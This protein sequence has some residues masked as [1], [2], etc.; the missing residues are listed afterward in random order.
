MRIN[1]TCKWEWESRSIDL[2]SRT[3]VTDDDR[4]P[5][6]VHRPNV[7]DQCSGSHESI[8]KATGCLKALHPL[9]ENDSRSQLGPCVCKLGRSTTICMTPGTRH[10]AHCSWFGMHITALAARS[11]GDKGVCILVAESL[12]SGLY[13]RYIWCGVVW[14]DA[15]WNRLLLKVCVRSTS[16]K[17]LS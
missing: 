6:L 17:W 14:C 4:C 1:L 11:P 3:A 9:I 15:R 5:H 13:K 10:G 16:S 8:T 12:A 7:N 2:A